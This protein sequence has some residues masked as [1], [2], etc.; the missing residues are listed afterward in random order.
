MSEIALVGDV[1]KPWAI[2]FVPLVVVAVAIQQA[3]GVPSVPVI[4][5]IGGGVG[6]GAMWHMRPLY[7]QF[8]PVRAL[9]DRMFARLLKP[10]RST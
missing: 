9:Y 1:I 7:L 3:I 10:L 4:L 6:L 8:G 2:R 5:A